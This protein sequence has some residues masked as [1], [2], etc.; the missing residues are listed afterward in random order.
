[1]AF[2]LPLGLGHHSPPK[3]SVSLGTLVHGGVDE[4]GRDKGSNPKIGHHT[5]SVYVG[6]LLNEA[7]KQWLRNLFIR[8][9]VVFDVFLSKKSKRPSSLRYAFVRFLSEDG[10]RKAIDVLNGEVIDDNRLVVA[11]ATTRKSESLPCF[12]EKSL[13]TPT[14][15]FCHFSSN[16]EGIPDSSLVQ[17]G[18]SNMPVI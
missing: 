6:N 11:E 14:T 17:K 7:S 18:M 5:F 8:F 9:G 13:T 3:P 12:G 16:L 15:D 1:M 4:D 2:S 10:V